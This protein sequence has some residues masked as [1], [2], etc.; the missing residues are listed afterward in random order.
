MAI[1]VIIEHH[2][3][4]NKIVYVCITAT[5]LGLSK[6][7]TAFPHVRI[8]CSE[9]DDEDYGADEEVPGMGDFGTRYYG[10]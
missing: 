6:V 9:I 8:V 2:V 5:C 3:P 4:E 10:A 1:M 7:V